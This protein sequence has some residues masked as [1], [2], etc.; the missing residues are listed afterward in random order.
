MKQKEGIKVFEDRKVLTLW[1]TEKEHWYFSI[2]EVIAVL[3]NQNDYQGA[4]NYW[5]VLNSDS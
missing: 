5:K 2:V 3:T 4:R 1:D